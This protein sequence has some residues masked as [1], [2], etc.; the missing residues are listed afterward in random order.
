[1]GPNVGQ[2][3]INALRQA[4]ATSQLIFYACLESKEMYVKVT[5]FVSKYS[6]S[7]LLHQQ[8]FTLPDLSKAI[9]VS[10]LLFT[11]AITFSYSHYLY[12]HH[13]VIK[14]TTFFLFSM[15]FAELSSI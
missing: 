7:S 4:E 3:N 8:S 12:V 9:A 13:Q 10:D 6:N 2:Q 14:F 5:A 15:S 1:M 11:T